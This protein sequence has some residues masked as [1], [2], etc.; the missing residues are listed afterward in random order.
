MSS[1]HDGGSSPHGRGTL[2]EKPSM[3]PL[4]WPVHPRTGGEHAPIPYTVQRKGRG[5]SP[6]GRGTQVRAP[7]DAIIANCARFI[8]ARAGNT[9]VRNLRRRRVYWRFIPARGGEHASALPSMMSAHACGFI[10]ARAGNT[11]SAKA[12]TLNFQL[13]VHPRTGRGTQSAVNHSV[14]MMGWFIPARAGNTP[15]CS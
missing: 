14:E 15:A 7:S 2:F 8:P 10:P 6:H 1:C 5:S 3:V 12:P 11:L 9:R 13:T 4:S